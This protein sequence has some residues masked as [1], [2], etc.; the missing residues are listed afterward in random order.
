MRFYDPFDDGPF[1]KATARRR[2]AV[3]AAPRALNLVVDD[4]SG[5]LR[6]P[7]SDKAAAFSE[8]AQR[9]RSGRRDR[10]DAAERAR[11]VDV[12]IKPLD[13]ECWDFGL[14]PMHWARVRYERW[15]TTETLL[16]KATPFETPFKKTG[17][18]LAQIFGTPT[19][20]A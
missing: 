5:E 19:R 12:A 6:L 17:G 14:D 11:R 1:V 8:V 2:D 7:I 3:P 9:V 15:E 13:A 20:A 16:D 4:I 18:F 10:L